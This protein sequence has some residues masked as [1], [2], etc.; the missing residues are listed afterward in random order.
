MVDRINNGQQNY[1]KEVNIDFSKINRDL[2]SKPLYERDQTSV[3]QDKA[4]L[5]ETIGYL[6]DSIKA[7]RNTSKNS[8]NYDFTNFNKKQD[9]DLKFL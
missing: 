8:V 7:G 5:K 2:V 4:S 9:S 1:A 3:G 6:Q